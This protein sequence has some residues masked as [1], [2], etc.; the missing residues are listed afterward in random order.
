MAVNS[1]CLLLSVN[2]VFTAVPECFL[3]LQSRAIWLQNTEAFHCFK[4]S[5]KTPF[6]LQD[7]K[8]SH[9]CLCSH[10]FIHITQ[11]VHKTTTKNSRDRVSQDATVYAHSLLDLHLLQTSLSLCIKHNSFLSSPCS[12]ELSFP[13]ECSFLTKQFEC[14]P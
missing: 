7:V 13:A 5:W 1:K 11:A 4:A 6:S 12:A 2:L 8:N 14:Q 10:Q 9:S 3:N